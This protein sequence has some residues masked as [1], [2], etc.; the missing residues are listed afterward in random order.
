MAPCNARRAVAEAMRD[1]RDLPP[2]HDVQLVVSELVTNSVVHG[3]AGE[4]E[5]IELSVTLFPYVVR[6]AVADP[7]G[8][9]TSPVA[10]VD[11]DGPGGRGLRIV[12]ALASRW[13]LRPGQP[14]QLCYEVGRPL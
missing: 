9:F 8:G 14:G 2:V 10:P 1:R 7:L 3:R 13:G 4:A 6:V 5:K 12:R 11:H